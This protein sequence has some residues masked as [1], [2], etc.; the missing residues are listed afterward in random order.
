MFVSSQDTWGHN[1]QRSLVFRVLK[2]CDDEATTVV[3]AG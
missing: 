3:A 2:D 1:D